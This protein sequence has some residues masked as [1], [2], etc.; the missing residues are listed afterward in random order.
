MTEPMTIH[1]C[2]YSVDTEFL[3]GDCAPRIFENAA[4]SLHLKLLH[5]NERQD[6]RSFIQRSSHTPSSIVDIAETCQRDLEANVNGT[7]SFGT[8][9]AILLYMVYEQLKNTQG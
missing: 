2:S 4:S 1:Q 3:V 7:S 6:S 8:S 9:R 5:R